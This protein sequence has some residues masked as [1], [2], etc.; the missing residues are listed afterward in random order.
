MK[1]NR[2]EELAM[3]RFEQWL[4]HCAE[5]EVGPS[6]PLAE[7][8]VVQFHAWAQRTVAESLG[9]P[10]DAGMSPECR[11]A[12]QHILRAYRSRLRGELSQR[13]NIK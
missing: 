8:S 2:D 7:K 3:R 12:I 1:R 4:E 5:D 13:P 9:L 6:V 10:A 11:A